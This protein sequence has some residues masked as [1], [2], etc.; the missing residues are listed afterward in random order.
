V[1]HAILDLDD[2]L[3]ATMEASFAAWVAA[4]GAAA[5]DRAA[6][7]DGYRTLTF[8]GC[9][10]RWLGPVDL[11]AFAAAYR[12][13]V[14]YEP[15]GDVPGLVAG[16]GERGVRAGIVT[17]STGPEAARKLAAA[18]IDAGLFDFVA[19]RAADGSHTKDL[20]RIL[21]GRGV[22][23]AGAVHVSDN[24]ADL[25][26]SAAAGVP[27]RGV[28]TG[29]WTRTDFVAAGVDPAAVHPDVHIALS[30]WDAV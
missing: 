5:P 18:G 7:A 27:F 23:P 17:N 6:F 13:A 3:I 30:T 21:A 28:L 20:R 22:E 15:I 11:D 14:R 10:A 1:R 25:A 24:P 19:A 26:P 16:L 2:T 8:A 29:A 4:A 12:E 9:V